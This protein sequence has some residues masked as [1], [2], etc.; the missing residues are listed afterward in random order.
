M[1]CDVFEL[2]EALLK[3]QKMQSHSDECV[4]HKR[5]EGGKKTELEMPNR[6]NVF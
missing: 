3:L 1:L 6:K 5:I 2:S 4:E